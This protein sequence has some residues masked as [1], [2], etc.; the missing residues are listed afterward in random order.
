MP[1]PF[2][3]KIAAVPGLSPRIEVLPDQGMEPDYLAFCNFP[4]SAKSLFNA[5]MMMRALLRAPLY[6][7]WV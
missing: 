2:R 4:L 5:V 6:E 1:S 3:K 7:V